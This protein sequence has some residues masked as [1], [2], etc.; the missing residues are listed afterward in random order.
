MSL[1]E[2]MKGDGVEKIGGVEERKVEGVKKEAKAE[3]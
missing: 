2:E 1:E 3:T